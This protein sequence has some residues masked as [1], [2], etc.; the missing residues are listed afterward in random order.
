MKNRKY[1]LLAIV[2]LAAAGGFSA[3]LLK[4]SSDYSLDEPPFNTLA[5]PPKSVKSNIWLDGGSVSV[6]ILDRDGKACELVFPVGR[7]LRHKTAFYGA[8][9]PNDPKAKQLKHPA[10]ARS[11]ALELITRYDPE[12]QDGSA[13]RKR[14]TDGRE[15]GVAAVA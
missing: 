13:Y 8:Y 10:R 5:M 14:S 15:P 9:V 6:S 2:L 4:H 11:I 12:G 1:L 3:R 7:G